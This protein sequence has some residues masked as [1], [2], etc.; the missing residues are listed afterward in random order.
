MEY[1]FF[2]ENILDTYSF[3]GNSIE[4]IKSFGNRLETD[5][6]SHS[7]MSMNIKRNFQYSKTYEKKLLLNKSLTD[8]FSHYL[9]I[10]IDIIETQIIICI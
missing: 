8:Y 1:S 6:V 9:E 5:S 4:Y 7:I 10:K 3:L 2:N